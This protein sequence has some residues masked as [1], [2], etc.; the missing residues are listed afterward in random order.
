M[1][2]LDLLTADHNRVR[3]LFARWREAEERDD[4]GEMI[5]MAAK[6]IEELE[7]HTTIEEEIFYPAVHDHSEEL[8][9]VVDEGVEEHHVAKVLI[10]ELANLEAGQAQWRAK[11]TVLIENVEH[12]AEEEEDEM[13]PMIRSA[14]SAT[15]LEELGERL[16]SR[17][18]ALGAPT[19]ADAAELSTG[20]LREK[21]KEQEIPGRSSMNAEELRATVDPR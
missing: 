20:E 14:A 8:A 7:V 1:N 11:M 12:H 13:F 9:D 2:A 15:T 19:P 10:D 16:E 21:A 17:K 5:T 18:G 3:G 6:I 4:Q